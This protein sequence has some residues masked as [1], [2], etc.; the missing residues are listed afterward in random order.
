MPDVLA[1]KIPSQISSH[2]HSKV[3]VFFGPWY[4]N[5]VKM[6]FVYARRV[7]VCDGEDSTFLD[8]QFHL[9]SSKP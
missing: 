2:G 6:V 9:P 3:L 4:C 8:I 1:V 5:V 7:F